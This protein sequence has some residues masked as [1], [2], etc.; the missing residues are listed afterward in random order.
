M[1]HVNQLWKIDT[2]YCTYITINHNKHR[3]YLIMI[4]DDCSSMIVGY[5]FFLEDK[6]INVQIVMKRAIIK[7]GIPKKVYTDNCNPYK[8]T[9]ITLIDAQLQILLLRAQP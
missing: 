4:I 8:N 7:Y 3:T 2:T 1:S 9:Q 5:S 6:A